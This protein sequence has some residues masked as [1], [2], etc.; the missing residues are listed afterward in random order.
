MASVGQSQTRQDIFFE[1]H[2]WVGFIDNPTALSF[3]GDEVK[4]GN[5]RQAVHQLRSRRTRPDQVRDEYAPVEQE[6]PREIKGLIVV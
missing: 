3:N 6:F 5:L 2:S 4:S 1:T